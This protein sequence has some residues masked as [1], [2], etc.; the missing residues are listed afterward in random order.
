MNGGLFDE[1]KNA[2][3][4]PNNAVVQLIMINLIVFVLARVFNVFFDI[5]GATDTFL[6]LFRKL[7]LPADIASLFLQPWTLVTYFFTHMD[8]SHI[9]FNMLFLFWFGRIIQEFFK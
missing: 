8:F 2:W 4:K 9:L 5:N 6:F 1:F 3:S 7:Q